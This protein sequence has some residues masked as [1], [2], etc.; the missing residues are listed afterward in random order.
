MGLVT[1]ALAS[2]ISRVAGLQDQT[3]DVDTSLSRYGFDSLMI[4]QLQTWIEENL[5]A[6]IAMVHLMR[7]PTTSELARAAARI[8]RRRG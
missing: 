5:G 3:V 2:I 6:S 8:R 7:G 4:A 1:S